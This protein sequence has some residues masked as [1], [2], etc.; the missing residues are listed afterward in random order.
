MRAL[1]RPS[2]TQQPVPWHF[3]VL[4][5]LRL[6]IRGEFFSRTFL[7]LLCIGLM[8]MGSPSL[9]LRIIR[10]GRAIGNRV[11]RTANE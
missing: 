9:R 5:R 3:R 10:A 8:P 4:V 7:S 2:R 6:K 1:P 11:F